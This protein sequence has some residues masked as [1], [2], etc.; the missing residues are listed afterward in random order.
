MKWQ[1]FLKNGAEEA[2][3]R[4]TLEKTVL[5]N[6]SNHACTVG[7]ILVSADFK[8]I[9]ENLIFYGLSASFLISEA[10]SLGLQTASEVF[11]DRTYQT[12]GSLTPRSQPNALIRETEKS[13]AQVLQMIQ[14]QTVAT[15]NGE[16]VSLKAETVCIHGDGANALEFARA[17]KVNLLANKVQISAA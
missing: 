5:Y 14:T 10:E 11:A 17:L 1:K 6:V 15:T 9:D 4:L 3:E 12:D 16:S 2:N 13:V 8:T 7:G